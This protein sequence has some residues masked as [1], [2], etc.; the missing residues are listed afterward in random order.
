LLNYYPKNKEKIKTKILNY[1]D[2][3]GFEHETVI[4]YRKKL[5]SIMFA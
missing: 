5:S 2:V 1:F 4:L 3:L